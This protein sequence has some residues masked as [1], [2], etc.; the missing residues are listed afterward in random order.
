[1]VDDL[2]DG[3][4]LHGRKIQGKAVPKVRDGSLEIDDPGD[5]D[6]ARAVPDGAKD[7]QR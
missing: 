4:H 2:S 5:T 1:L 3:R 7:R 6:A